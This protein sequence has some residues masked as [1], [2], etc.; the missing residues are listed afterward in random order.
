MAAAKFDNSTID[1]VNTKL[2]ET[3]DQYINYVRTVK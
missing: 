2:L 1:E 3:L